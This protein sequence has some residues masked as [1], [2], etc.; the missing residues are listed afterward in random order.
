[1][2]DPRILTKLL[3]ELPTKMGKPLHCPTLDSPLQKLLL[4]FLAVADTLVLF[5]TPAAMVVCHGCCRSDMIACCRREMV[6][7]CVRDMVS[8]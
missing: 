7:S 8:S 4:L 5:L 6:T 2:M 1:M 3:K